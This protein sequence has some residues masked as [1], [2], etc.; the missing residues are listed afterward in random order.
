MLSASLLLAV[1]LVVGQVEQ[2]ETTKEIHVP[3]DVVKAL[4]YFVGTWEVKVVGT[5]ATCTTHNQW[6]DGRPC[7]HGR[8]VWKDANGVD[9]GASMWGYDPARKQIVYVQF[10]ASGANHI[11]KWD[12]RSGNVWKGTFRGTSADA[13]EETANVELEKADDDRFV[14]RVAAGETAEDE[15][16]PIVTMIFQRRKKS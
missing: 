13:E 11:L 10:Y 4:D 9:I 2:I 7:L 5:T 8:L 3:D 6:A 12:Y 1:S 15:S 16:S 14:L